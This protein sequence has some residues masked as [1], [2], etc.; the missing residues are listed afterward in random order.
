MIEERDE[1]FYTGANVPAN[2]IQTKT[3]LAARLRMM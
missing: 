2:I 3:V 1:K